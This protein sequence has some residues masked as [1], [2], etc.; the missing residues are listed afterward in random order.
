M[1][2]HPPYEDEF[3]PYE[4]HRLPDALHGGLI[5]EERRGRLH[6]GLLV[7]VGAVLVF[8]CW[9]TIATYLLLRG[10]LE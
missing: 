7:A 10:V 3:P 4:V 2:E 8:G 9:G 6:T 1:M 5:E